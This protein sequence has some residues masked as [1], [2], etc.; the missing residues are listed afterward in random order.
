MYGNQET[1]STTDDTS[2]PGVSLTT[3]PN[4][5]PK[6]APRTTSPNLPPVA[7]RTETGPPHVAPRTETGPPVVPRNGICVECVIV[8][9]DVMFFVCDI[10]IW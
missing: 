1:I 6:P 2:K 5:R 8:W 10:E 3:D 4:R 9:L 7:P